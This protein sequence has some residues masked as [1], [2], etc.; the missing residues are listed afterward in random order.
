LG[1]KTKEMEEIVEVNF[2]N[3]EHC[4]AFI[5]LMNHYMMD[6]MGDCKPHTDEENARLIDGLSKQSNRLCLLYKLNTNYIG[7]TN[8]FIGF[9]TFA[10][11]PFINI[12]DLIVL[13]GYRGNGIGRKL[14]NKV[15]DIALEKGCG[16]MTLEV[17]EDNS[18]AQHLYKS[19]D[20]KEC[21]PVMHFW[22]KYL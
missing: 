5:M 21:Q 19:L 3:K 14:L 9:G 18:K 6:K 12:H 10:A 8:C 16:K 22:T 11:K 20:F 1:L 15:S 17:R 4:K 2:K 13:D 7:L